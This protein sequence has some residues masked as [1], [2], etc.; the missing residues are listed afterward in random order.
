[1]FNDPSKFLR[2]L[3]NRLVPPPEA[4]RLPDV[5]ADPSPPDASSATS[6]VK[7]SKRG[8]EAAYRDR[9]AL[10]LGGTTEVVTPL[11]RIDIVTA[12][13]IIE[14]KAAAQWKQALG[15][16]LVYGRDYPMHQKRIHLFGKIDPIVLTE[17][18]SQCGRYQ[19]SVTWEA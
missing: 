10:S 5:H 13:E 3:V 16:I 2:D 8:T 6:R 9:L 18:R 12:T 15:Q 14:V 1:M 19:V 11:G 17:A 4:F 7:S